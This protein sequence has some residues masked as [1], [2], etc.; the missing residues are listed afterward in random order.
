MEIKQVSFP[1][2]VDLLLLSSARSLSLSKTLREKTVNAVSQGWS[3]EMKHHYSSCTSAPNLKLPNFLDPGSVKGVAAHV[4]RGTR[5]DHRL[6]SCGLMMW[7]DGGW[8]LVQRRGKGKSEK[9]SRRRERCCRWQPSPRE[10]KHVSC[11]TVQPRAA[12][13]TCWKYS[14]CSVLG[15]PG[16]HV[17][18]Q[19][20]RL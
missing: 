16:K 8:C 6:D 14:L 1:V 2:K 10:D 12:H 20:P 3:G 18:I 13:S 9:W 15:G 5:R 17:K 4:S 11:F 19:L 7:I